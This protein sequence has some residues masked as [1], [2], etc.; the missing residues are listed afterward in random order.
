MKG[1]SLGVS[2]GKQKKRE[3]T[4]I[5]PTGKSQ[6]D[7]RRGSTDLGGK[8]YA[9]SAVACKRRPNSLMTLSTVANYGLLSG[10]AF[11]VEAY[12]N[13]DRPTS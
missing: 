12:Y 7:K 5:D 1:E 8:A 4:S 10:E 6:G 13:L 3:P 2:G 11:R 9:C